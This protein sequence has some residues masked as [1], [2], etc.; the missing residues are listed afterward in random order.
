MQMNDLL[1]KISDWKDRII[2]NTVNW[3]LKYA[4]PLSFSSAVWTIASFNVMSYEALPNG[5]PDFTKPVPE[6]SYVINNPL[7]NHNMVVDTGRHQVLKSILGISTPTPIVSFPYLGVGEDYT[8]PEAMGQTG[9]LS[10]I[11]GGNLTARQP[12]V[13]AGGGSFTDSDI[14]S[15]HP[16]GTGYYWMVVG[17]VTYL[18]T[19]LV[20]S[21]FGEFGLFSV[22]T[23][24]PS[25][26]M[27]D[28]FVN[29]AHFTKSNTLAVVVQI[30]LRA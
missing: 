10:E 16:V 6:C 11:V 7:V 14:V 19:D 21:V 12:L 5:Q 23:F 26:V 3:L 20:G 22:S 27:Y 28:R 25:G 30:T 8:T 24:S 4:K 18:A 15:D 1:E 29:Q 13:R 17:Q 2:H 9:L